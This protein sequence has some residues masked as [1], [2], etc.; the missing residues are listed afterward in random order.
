M[1]EYEEYLKKDDA[2][3]A[4]EKAYKVAEE[5]VKALA[6]KFKLKEYDKALKEGK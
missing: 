4:S 5:L 6:E 1:K 2:V 3:Q